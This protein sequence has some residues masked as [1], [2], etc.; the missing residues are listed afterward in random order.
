MAIVQSKKKRQITQ[1][2]ARLSGR[3]R[4]ALARF[5]LIPR[6]D[7]MGNGSASGNFPSA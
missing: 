5:R 2:R 3:T 6:V 1:K 4:P 7:C